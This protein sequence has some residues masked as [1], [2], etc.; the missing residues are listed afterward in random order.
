MQ[1]RWQS[2]QWDMLYFPFV[3]SKCKSYSE[4]QF[5]FF[6]TFSITFWLGIIFNNLFL[7][8]K[9]I[10]EQIY[11]NIAT[12]FECVTTIY[13]IYSSSSSSWNSLCANN[14][15]DVNFY[16]NNV[17]LKHHECSYCVAFKKNLIYFSENYFIKI[18]MLIQ[19]F[20]VIWLVMNF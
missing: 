19:W 9:F 10:Y 14:P 1:C 7:T 11:L 16:S 2:K 17:F 20:D 4:L 6:F 12:C 15:F 8:W 5:I 3:V 13:T 18:L